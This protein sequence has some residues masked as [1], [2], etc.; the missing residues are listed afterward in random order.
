MNKGKVLPRKLKF[1]ITWMLYYS[2]AL[3]QQEHFIWKQN[4]YIL[5]ES[6]FTFKK[7]FKEC[8]AYTKFY[9]MMSHWEPEGRY[10]HRLCTAIVSFWFSMKYCWAFLG[11]VVA[12]WIRPQ[13]T[14]TISDTIPTNRDFNPLTGDASYALYTHKLLN[15]HVP[16]GSFFRICIEYIKHVQN[17]IRS[18]LEW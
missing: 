15:V 16:V 18:W 10:N 13:T 5:W 14:K 1:I 9:S 11:A 12:Q 17:V 6:F 3:K 2:H 7:K 4:K 8:R